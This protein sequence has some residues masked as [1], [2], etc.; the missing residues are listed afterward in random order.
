NRKTTYTIYPNSV[1]PQGILAMGGGSVFVRAGGSVD[2]QVGAFGIGD[3][4]VYAGG[5]LEGRFLVRGDVSSYSATPS[6]GTLVAMGNFGMPEQY[7]NGV[8]KSW[9]QLIEMSNAQMSVT[10][11]GNVELGA[12]LNPDLAYGLGSSTGAYWDNTYTPRSSIS[13]TAVTGDV[14]MYGVIDPRYGSFY[15]SSSGVSVLPA[16]VNIAAVGDIDM[17]AGFTQLPAQYGALTMFARGN[18]VFSN[19]ALWLMS[20]TDPGS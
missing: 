15:G 13:L 9:P 17:M 3:L 4:A 12:V 16:S 11:M 7:I 19:G 8:L 14:N 2:A 20:D 1:N 6:V 18:I 5:D 10:A